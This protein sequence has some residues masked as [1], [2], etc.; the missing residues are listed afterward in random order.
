M[1]CCCSDKQ[2]VSSNET[3]VLLVASAPS[4]ED[5]DCVPVDPHV[6]SGDV[7]RCACPIC[8]KAILTHRMIATPCNS[9]EHSQ[10]MYTLGSH[11]CKQCLDDIPCPHNQPH[12]SI[13]CAETGQPSVEEHVA[14]G[15]QLLEYL[16]TQQHSPGG[17]EFMPKQHPMD[18]L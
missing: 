2:A 11:T 18:C 15:Q 6:D 17:K 10:G 4:A 5:S 16:M 7:A 3:A 12:F 13:H 14:E 8:V 9:C 1:I